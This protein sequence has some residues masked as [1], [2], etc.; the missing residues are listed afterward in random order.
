MT[1]TAPDQVEFLRRAGMPVRSQ[2]RLTFT[3][4]VPGRLLAYLE[5]AGFIPGVEPYTVDTRVELDV[6]PSGVRMAL[7][8]DA[9]H[10]ERWTRLAIMG[11]ES[12]LV[13]LARALDARARR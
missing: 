6:A 3:E 9:M 5:Q 12:E 8:F 7:T 13:K 1:A 2:H 4:I 11:R 10:D